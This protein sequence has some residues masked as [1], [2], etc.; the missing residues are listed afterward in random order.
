MRCLL[1]LL[2][3]ALSTSWSRAQSLEWSFSLGDASSQVANDVVTPVD[4]STYVVGHF[5]GNVDF[6]PGAGNALIDASGIQ[7]GYLAAYDDFGSYY[8]AV[9]VTSASSATISAVAVDSKN[10]VFVAGTFENTLNAPG[11]TQLSV[12]VGNEAAFV[13]K[14]DPQTGNFLWAEAIDLADPMTVGDIATDGT[15]V[16]VIGTYVSANPAFEEVFVRKYD[17]ATGGAPVI[18][19]SYTGNQ[20]DYGL[21]IVAP[22]AGAHY[23]IVGLYKNTIDFGHGVTLSGGPDDEGFLAKFEKVDG[24]AVTAIAIQGTAPTSVQEIVADGNGD[25]WIAGH[26]TNFVTPA[27]G[28]QLSKTGTQ[29]E[30]FFAKYDNALNYQLAGVLGA[31][32]DDVVSSVAIDASDRIY[33]A[34]Q[35]SNTID[36][37]PGGGTDS[38]TP[39][40]VS[41]L[42]VSILDTDSNYINGFQIGGAGATVNPAGITTRSGNRL[43]LHGSFDNAAVDFDPFAVGSQTLSY[44]DAGD[45]F[46]EDLS[47]CLTATAEAGVDALVCF[48]STHQLAATATNANSILWT[49]SGT[50][51]FND[52]TAEDPIYTFSA[53]DIAAGTVNLT[54]S[55]DGTCNDPSSDVVL[56]IDPEATA[57]AG[58]DALVCYNSTHQLAATATN[59]NSILWTTSGTGTFN[60]DTAEDPIY[61]FSAADIASGTVTLTMSVTGNCNNPSDGVVLTIDPEAT[62]DAGSDALVCFNSTHQLAATAT[63]ANAILW[64]TSGTGTFNDDTAEDPIYSFSA[65]DIA[66]G[67]VTLT[68]S[69]AGNCNNPSD[70]VVL[71]IDP[72]ATADAGSDALVCFNSTHQLVA[73]ATNANSILWTTSGTGTFNDD[74]AEDPIYTFSAADIAAGTVTLTMSVNGN[75]NNPSDGVV[76]TVDPEATADAGSDALVC[77]NSTHQLAATATNANSILW[78]TSGTGTF[79]DDTAED[80]I[81]TFSAADIA[82]GT[83]TLTMSVAG[84]CNNPSDGVVLTVDPEATADAGSDALVCFNSTH[85]LAATATNANSILW[86]TSGTGTFNDDTAEDPIYTFSAAD[87]AAGTVTLTM[88]VTGNC[89]NPSDGVVLTVDPEATADAGSD[90]LVCF[91]STHQLAATATNANSILWTTS[92]SGTF[93]DDTAED[94]IYT[95]SAA[96]IAAGTVTL[97]M[98]V[99]GSC[100]DPSS[101]V[102]L[103]IDPEATADAGSDALVCYNSTHQLAATATNANSIL[104]TTSGTGTFNDDTAEDPIYTFSAADIAAGTVNLTMSVDGTCNDPSSDV[105]LTIDPEATADAGSDALVCFNSTHQLAATATNANSIL[106]TT[107][108][109]GTFNDDTAEDPIYTFSAADIAAGTVTLTMSVTGNCNNPSDG[110]VLTIDP[111]ATADAGSDAL[112]CYNSTHQLAATAT[113]ANSILWTTS[114]TGTFNDDTAE[115]PIYTFS[116]A[117]IAAGTVTLTMSVAGNCNNPSDGVVL[118]IDPE[119]TADAGSDALVCFNRTHQLAATATNAN[120]ILWTTSGTGT[121]NDDTAEDPIYTFSAADIAAGTVTLTMSVTGNCNNP[122]DGVVLTIDPEATADAGSDALVCYNSTH[123]LAATA[124]NANSILWTTSGTGTFNDDTA[125]DPIYTF[126]AADIAAGTVTLT[127]SVTGNCNNPSDG[128]VLTVDP[129]ATA[130]AGSDALVCFNSTH[131]LAA[132]ATN[133]NSILWTTSGTGTFNDDTA[134]DPIYT[135]SAADIAAGTV[136]LTMS[137]DGTC[138]DPSSD[139]VLTIDPEATADAGSD[140]L[141]CYNSTH[142]LAATATNANSILWTTSGTG[143]FNDDTAEDPIYTFSAADIAAGTVTLTMSV[144]G[145][146]NNPSD[147]VVLTIDPEATADAGSDALVCYNSTHQL[148]ATA[149]NA[150]SILWTTSGTGTFNDDTAEDPIYTFSAADIAA[151]TVTLTMSVAGNCN[152]PSDGVVLTVD[153]EATA[154]AGSDALVCYNSTHQLAATAT[155]A[156][157]ILWTTSGTGTFNDDTAEDAIYTFSAAD[158]AAGTVTLTMSVNGNCNNPSDGVVLTVDPGPTTPTI[159]FLVTNDPTPEITGTA[160]AGNALTVVVAGATYTTLADGNGDWLI[161]TENDTPISGT[162]NPDLNGT[163]EVGVTAS[164]AGCDNTDVSANELT[165]DTTDPAIPTVNPLV[166]NDDTPELSGEAESGSTV[167]V[168]VAGATYTTTSDGTWTVDTGSDTPTAGAF[169]PVINGTNEVEVTS[170]DAA[171]NSA[172][173]VTGDELEIDQI[174]PGVTINELNSSDAT[175]LITGTVDDSDADIEVTVDGQ[176]YPGVVDGANWSAQVTNALSDG[177]YNVVVAATDEAGNVGTDSSSDELVLNGTSVTPTVTINSLETFALSPA[178]SG[179]VDD[180]DATIEVAVDG[181]EYVGVNNGD[182]TWSLDAGTIV[183]LDVDTYDVVVRA[184]SLSNLVGTD[185]TGDELRILPSAATLEEP[186]EISINSFKATWSPLPGGVAS[187]VLEVSAFEDFSSIVASYQVLVG[188]DN[189]FV[190]PGLRYS[191]NYYVRVQVLYGSGDVS[192]YSNTQLARTL[193]NPNTEVDSLA[194]VAIYDETGGD[195]WTQNTNWK[196]DR[197]D[198]WF[199]VTVEDGR[200]TG[201]DLSNNNLSGAILDVASGLGLLRDLNLSSNDLTGI[202]NVEALTSLETADV[203]IN[204]LPFGAFQNLKATASEVI[205]ANQGEVLEPIVTLEEIGT[206]YEFDRQISGTGNVYK[207]FKDDTRIARSVATFTEELTSFDQDGVYH[208]EITNAEFPDLTLVSS[209]ITLKVS[210]LERDGIALLALYNATG[211]DF[212]TNGADWPDNPNVDTWEGVTVSENRVT[213]LNLKNSNLVGSVPDALLDIINLQF[214]D[215]SENFITGIPDLTRLED[216]TAPN[217]SDNLLDFADL[218]V[219]A[220]IPSINYLNQ[221]PFGDLLE[222]RVRKGATYNIHLDVGGSA[223]TYRWEFVGKVDGGL[224]NENSSSLQIKNLNYENMGDYTLVVESTLVPDLELRSEP[225]TI[226]AITDMDISPV[227]FDGDGKETRLREGEAFLYEVSK[228]GPFDTIQVETINSAGIKFKDVVLGDY[229]VSVRTDTLLVT[230]SGGQVDSVRLL[231]TYY[232]SSFLWEEAETILL[233]EKFDDQLVM[234]KKPTDVEKGG[235][236]INLLVEADFESE[237][238]ARVQTRRKVKRAGCSLRRRRR[239]TGGRGMN[240]D[241]EYELIAYKETDDDGRVSFPDLPD[242]FYKLNIEYPGVPMDPNSYIEFEIGEGGLEDNTLT[243]EATVDETGIIVELV[244]VLALPRDYL[245]HLEVYPNPVVNE[246]MVKYSKRSSSELLLIMTDLNGKT[247]YQESLERGFDKEVEVDVSA[248]NE[249]IYLLRLYSPQGEEGIATHKLV[250]SRK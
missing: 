76:L 94:P 3:V 209:S 191:T 234:Q 177:T 160:D 25:L 221:K 231:P 142:Q 105:V 22:T 84:N 67:T 107:S 68:M 159:D 37:D 247:V 186:T 156:N 169:S 219:N 155:N 78:T 183:D 132:T 225:Q 175:P 98:S 131:Q 79:N 204:R 88:S 196:T 70:G 65:A 229:L 82:A 40:G 148:A 199:G 182:G 238:E 184:T 55:V 149:A 15:D 28:P 90:A 97:T 151:G 180:A 158:I 165:I 185:N 74:T 63:N 179:E 192:E 99:D 75:C 202:G 108:G 237:D 123:Q 226:L 208:V 1:F 140:A 6:D 181:Q 242:G 48:N 33:I 143:T 83:V 147:G 29:Q 203:T 118:T 216:L 43:I 135:F 113:N 115:D 125:E 133:A 176:S 201:L 124:T 89:N 130:D 77:Y 220:T 122:S 38:R 174:S 164:E 26:F 12:G 110:V 96:D 207:W 120:S 41:D 24:D 161:D 141:V 248:F 171:L 35:F 210:S 54:M 126:S 246:L 172:S 14:F 157:S 121:F 193:T 243:L 245:Q 32:G 154:D 139:V 44:A 230:R 152:N 58:S 211:G 27:G 235:N 136:N 93:N 39:L 138:N 80:P 129:E 109:T 111:E 8:L 134:E 92:G 18:T 59:A 50:G 72:E 5:L 36:L 13:A 244:E 213:E 170:T 85:Q 66:S 7:A 4:D 167:T 52:D 250:I 145:N 119:A 223:N 168:T 166:T 104:W 232:S 16:Y 31:N 101:D 190:V 21:G 240:E 128:V 173:D 137:V 9:A 146:C 95:F 10:D 218:E 87:I 30:I 103:T 188:G 215:L 153:P 150:N 60:D 56:T 162:F 224:I 51:T 239:A 236:E 17:G 117:D 69:V 233:R 187:Y 19:G 45:V 53:A 34:G 189:F 71:T 42:F 62:A 106:W 86:T 228:S 64:T 200:V 23:F 178:L 205:Y 81:Y 49:T 114:G 2:M 100:N 206:S 102:V 91:N 227:Y 57:D 197:L 214:L 20:P 217:V 194:L 222:A 46:V 212:W 61:T 112:V 47:L 116:A 144:A 11:V 127:M 249:G 241:D 73:T 198:T 195:N 163:N